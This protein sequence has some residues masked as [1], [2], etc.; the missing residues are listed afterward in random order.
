MKINYF[1]NKSTEEQIKDHLWRMDSDFLPPLHTYVA[2]DDYAKKLYENAF[3]ID[4]FVDSKL[5]GLI[6]LYYNPEEKFIFVSNF[7]I[8]KEYR[9]KGMA[10]IKTL[11]DF[12][13]GN[14]DNADI[15][16]EMQKVGIEFIKVL[17]EIAKPH[18]PVIKS[19]RTEVRN[20]NRK[21]LLLYKRLGFKEVDIKNEF[22]Y[23]IKEI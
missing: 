7:S 6:G 15:S 2:I 1:F 17:K 14:Y 11:M 23:L 8:E 3:R 4:Y 10:L 18:R 21:S 16:S 9:G 13:A 20:A 5:I 22:T 19:L 12:A